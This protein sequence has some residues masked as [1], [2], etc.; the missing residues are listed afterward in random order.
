MAN[1]SEDSEQIIEKQDNNSDSIDNEASNQEDKVDESSN[2][3]NN[4]QD[5]DFLLVRG[6]LFIT[7]FSLLITFIYTRRG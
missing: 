6:I 3:V 2:N 7:F 4:S 5:E 1:E